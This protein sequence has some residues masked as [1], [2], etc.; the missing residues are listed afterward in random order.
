MKPK[1]VWATLFALAAGSDHVLREQPISPPPLYKMRHARASKISNGE[2]DGVNPPIYS[3]TYYNF[4][5]KTYTIATF[6][7]TS[8]FVYILCIIVWLDSLQVR[9]RFAR[10][11][12]AGAV[13][14]HESRKALLAAKKSRATKWS[15]SKVKTA[16]ALYRGGLG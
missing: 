14:P 13:Q 16:G 10:N 9:G 8:S 3:F 4:P 1:S 11:D 2:R 12:D 6:P 7:S 15:P 5:F